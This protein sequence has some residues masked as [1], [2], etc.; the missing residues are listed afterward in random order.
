MDPQVEIKI[1]QKLTLSGAQTTRRLWLLRQL[2]RLICEDETL[3]ALDGR[4]RSHSC[5]FS[6]S[7]LVWWQHFDSSKFQ[8]LE[9]PALVSSKT[10]DKSYDGKLTWIDDTIGGVVEELSDLILLFECGRVSS[11]VVF[12]HFSRLFIRIVPI[13]GAT[14]FS[15]FG[16]HLWFFLCS[17]SVSFIATAQLLFLGTLSILSKINQLFRKLFHLSRLSRYKWELVGIC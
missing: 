10:S 13:V 14:R 9:N 15:S 4:R 6:P 16:V 7:E 11:N 3:L 17:K 8:S 12:L 1:I 2:T 5:L